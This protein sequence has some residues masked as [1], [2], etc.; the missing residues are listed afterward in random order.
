MNSVADKPFPHLF[1]PL[2]LGQKQASNR[3]FRAATAT[4][5]AE[6]FDIS[7]RL[8]AHYAALARGGTG[9]VVTEA[10]R[11]HPSAVVRGSNI[12]GF[13]P[14]II[15]GLTRWAQTVH[16][17]GAL[18]IG[19]V[20]HSGRQHNS[21]SIPGRLIGPSAIACPRS[22][23]VPHAMSAEDIN[24]FIKHTV[25][26][27]Q[28]MAKAGFDGIE[29]HCAQGHLL[30]QFLSPFSNRRTDE[31]GGSWDNRIRFLREILRGLRAC[32]PSDFI[33]GIRLGVDEFTEGG[34]TLDMSVQLVRQ[35]VDERLIDYVSLSQG[36]FNTIDTHLPDRHHGQAP[37]QDLH[38][39][40]KAAVPQA[41]TITATRIVTPE[42]ADALIA[43]GVADA[44][45][46]GRALTADPDWPR[47]AQRGEAAD[48]RLCLGCNHCWDGLHEGSAVLTCVHNPVV[49]RETE[50]LTVEPAAA[51]ATIVVLGGG[52]AGMEAARM[53]AA[54]GH[55][56]VLFEK[57]KALGGKA[58][59]GSK[60][61]GHHEYGYVASYLDRQV[62]GSGN[63][64]LRLGESA[65]A[66]AV[67]ALA[68]KTVI[69]ATGA[70]SV[71]P[72]IAGDGS[73]PLAALRTLPRSLAGKHVML[74]DED[75]YW[76]AAQAAEE[77]VGRGAKLTLV[78]RFFEPFRELPTVSRIATLRLL[79]RKGATILALH[80][81]KRVSS[82]GVIVEHYA[83]GR[84]TTV[85]DVDAI[86]SI[87]PQRPN[88]DCVPELRAAGISDIRIVGD[89]FTPRRLRHAIHDAHMVARAV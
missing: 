67:V 10:M 28:N 63:I 46:L 22:G 33:V 88:D 16:S 85:A 65:S 59:G 36:N 50:L 44:V 70:T 68:P 29:V 42:Q 24:D 21:T 8:L 57:E 14:K 40:L 2:R 23:G 27:G 62:R 72:E 83:S 87:G 12:P 34:W 89:A 35:F 77:T 26:A 32:A 11:L 64:Q 53:A 74:L 30:Q 6:R 52:P 75:G 43:N 80:Q 79:D 18:L 78:T 20:N 41:T 51:P 37:F 39:R 55:R 69:V 60:V 38:A 61:G 73:V 15:P 56:V 54:R 4:N 45:A 58:F 7:D 1:S 17:A 3:I 49:G 82:G 66:Q 25:I 9:V 76:W 47:K 81:L 86:V 84:E 13:D 19:Q 5:L 48:I 71:D 31:W